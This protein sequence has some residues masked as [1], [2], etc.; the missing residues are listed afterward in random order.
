[1]SLSPVK[2]V[3]PLPFCSGILDYPGTDLSLPPLITSLSPVIMA[4]RFS[5][6]VFK[7]ATAPARFA[8][9][10][11]RTNIKTLL[12]LQGNFRAY[13]PILQKA[14]E[15]TIENVVSVLVA[16]EQ[17]LPADIED[18]TPNER[19]QAVTD[20]LARGERHLLAALGEMYRSYR[21]I[22]AEK[23]F[24]IENPPQQELVARKR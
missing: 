17:S 24:I 10:Q 3:C 15:E 19:Q 16:A 5:S 23:N 21:L 13:E 4:N 20:S 9:K 1:M 22:T 18:M 8:L 12:E 7:L 6:R 2:R 14:A 11:T